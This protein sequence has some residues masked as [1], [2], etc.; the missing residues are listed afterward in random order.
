MGA[1]EKQHNINRRAQAGVSLVEVIVVVTIAG[2]LASIAFPSFTE[3]FAR[4]RLRG[5]AES[6]RSDLN[7]ARSEAQKRNQTIIMNFDVGGDGSWCYG[8]RANTNCNCRETDPPSSSYCTLDTDAAGVAVPTNVSSTRYRGI[9][10]DAVPFGGNL[11]FSPVRP[12]LAAGSA[13]LVSDNI[14]A[15]IRVVVSGFGRIRF[16]SPSGSLSGYSSC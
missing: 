12:S 10:L 15:S 6:L 14:T 2:I 7:L 8:I 13:T 1:M 11:S 4:S 16:C 9:R 3:M 5:A